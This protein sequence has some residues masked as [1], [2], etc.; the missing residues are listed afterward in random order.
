MR[1]DPDDRR[2]IERALADPEPDNPIVRALA[3]GVHGFTSR[4]QQMVQLDGRWPSELLLYRPNTQFD[5][6]M[7]RLTLRVIAHEF[8]QPIAVHWLPRTDGSDPSPCD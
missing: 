1:F 2:S 7:I 4:I 3:R 5:D 6:I 8:H